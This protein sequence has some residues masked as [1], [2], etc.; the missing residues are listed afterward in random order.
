[1]VKAGIATAPADTAA[2][3]NGDTVGGEG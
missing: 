3:A 2:K 1:V